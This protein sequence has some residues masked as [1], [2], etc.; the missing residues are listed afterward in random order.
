MG[1]NPSFTLT[2][3]S[4][5]VTATVAD[6]LSSLILTTE[7]EHQSDELSLT[8]WNTDVTMPLRKPP[9]GAVLTL[10]LGYEGDLHRMGSFVVSSLSG[11][12]GK[13]TGRVMEI[14]ARAVPYSETPDGLSGFQTQK[15]HSWRKGTTIEDMVRRMAADH[16]MQA[17]V[18]A[19][20]A[21]IH[22]QHFDQTD[23][24]DISF[25]QKLAM[26]YDAVAKPSGGKLLFLSRGDAQS[27][28]GQEIPPVSLTSTQISEWSW[29]EDRHITPGTVVALYH[30]TRQARTYAV[31]VGSGEPVRRLRRK[32]R[33]VE[34][35]RA[36]AQAEMGRRARSSME[37]VL[38]LPGDASLN[39]GSPLVL[40]DSF[41]EGVDGNWII[42]RATHR[43]SKE[44]GFITE[45][46]CERPNDDSTVQA[47]VNGPVQVEGL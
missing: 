10:A 36:A 2:A 31:S 9:V 22:L 12:C 23:E 14:R 42:R 19:A 4:R 30:A 47:L 32:F 21:G 17:G 34:D 33:T 44:E 3:N 24:S 8:L 37:L 41:D 45:L 27:A 26:S 18:S 28:S 11:R 15:T 20:L 29:S 46:T 40:D 16:G 39:G 5:D 1:L 38:T 35:A 43:L 6:R 13:T 7:T 25:L